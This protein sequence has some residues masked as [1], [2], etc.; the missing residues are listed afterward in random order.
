MSR[1][2]VFS[3]DPA[4]QLSSNVLNVQLHGDA[5][6]SGQGI[7]QEMLMMSGTPHFDVGGTVHLIVNNQIGYTTPGDR[8]RSTRYCSDL[9]KSINAPVFHVNGDNPEA[10]IAVTKLAVDYQ[11]TFRKDVF[12]DFMC[13]RRWGHNELDD[14]MFTNPAVYKV[15]NNRQSVPDMYAKRLINHGVLT[16]EQVNRM[17]ESYTRYLNEELANLNSYQP[18]AS[19]FKKQWKDIEQAPASITTWDTGMDYNILH[20]V[21]KQ[22]VH[23]PENFVSF[24]I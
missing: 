12:I 3:S 19:Y 10:L 21:G 18:D 16:E 6:F 4:Q 22:S 13:F 15:I 1:D 14:P 20:H 9:A 17:A 2:G 24:D 7:N 11:R 5:A 23:I 8:G